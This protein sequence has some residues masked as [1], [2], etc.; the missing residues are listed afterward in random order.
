MA[1]TRL[2]TLS[3]PIEFELDREAQARVS[4]GDIAEVR[5][6]PI[7]NPVT[8]PRAPP[9]STCPTASVQ[10]GRDGQH[11]QRNHRSTAPLDLKFDNSYAQLAPG[12]SGVQG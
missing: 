1:P 5:V 4:I 3:A 12:W 2:K 6:E 8:G 10:A 9:A 11:R 7:T